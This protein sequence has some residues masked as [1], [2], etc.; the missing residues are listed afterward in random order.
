M[1]PVKFTLNGKQR[2]LY[3]DWNTVADFEDEFDT[4]IMYT[5]QKKRLGMSA[6]RGL[7]WAGM[8]HEDDS[9]EVKEVGN[10]LQQSIQDQEHSLASLVDPLTKALT[11]S[12]LLDVKAKGEQKP[13]NAK[14]PKSQ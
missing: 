5:L 1:K 14:N 7:F 8:L 10:M 11:D 3:F 13:K 2:S 9:L 4:S 12:G 6:M